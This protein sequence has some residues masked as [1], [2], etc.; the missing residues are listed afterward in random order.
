MY[1]LAIWSQPGMQCALTASRTRTLCLAR[2][3]ISAGGAPEASHRPADDQGQPGQR[4]PGPGEVHS[5]ATVVL[6]GP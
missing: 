5:A 6:S 2:A 4:D 3:A 1:W